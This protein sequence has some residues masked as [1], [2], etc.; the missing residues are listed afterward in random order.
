MGRSRYQQGTVRL[1]GKRVKSW[2]GG[3]HSYTV[4]ADG[5]EH[6]HNHT[7]T[8]GPK[9]QMTKDDAKRKLRDIIDRE[10]SHAAKVRP[11][12]DVTFDWF[13]KNNY[14]Q[15]KKGEWSE[16]TRS[17]VESVM[18]KHVLGVFGPVKLGDLSKLALQTHLYTV[19]EKWS[20]SV[21]KKVRVYV[22]AA[23]EEAVDQDYIG[24]NP[25]RKL[26]VGK[27]RKPTKRNHT[28]DEL[29]RLF[30]SLTGEDH[31]ILRLFVMAAL[32][33]G[34]QFA[35]KWLDFKHDTLRIERAVRRV[36]KGENRVGD[37][38]TEGSIGQVYLPASLQT[39][40]AHW[41]EIVRPCSDNEYI[42]GSRKGTP[43]DSHNY[44][45]RHLKPLAA[46]LGVPNLTFQSL[47]RSFATLMQGKGTPKD[48]QTQLRH[49]D[50][51]TTLNI[52]TQPI[53]ESVKRS[54]EALD[55]ELLK[56]LDEFGRESEAPVQ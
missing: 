6:R 29:C 51:L 27:T 18:K 9:S 21:A 36:K 38:K 19:A 3:W 5:V 11:N 25:A 56:V 52:Y 14:L 42:F 50:I 26:V 46:S 37:P 40:L 17:S 49:M 55:A 15:M 54:V 20:E 30:A 31:L 47:R 43:K 10:T 33:P 24:K 44:L 13:W 7:R 35:L 16:A 48:A 34:E 22:R 41:K 8:L 23:L 53:P 32:R 39:E 12:P 2:R 45:R 4:D 1:V 28:P